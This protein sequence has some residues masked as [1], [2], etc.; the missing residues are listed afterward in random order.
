MEK[1]DLNIKL[2]ENYQ[3]IIYSKQQILNES[4]E[5]LFD[6]NNKYLIAINNL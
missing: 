5:G 1:F 3:I 6:P 2:V 4:N